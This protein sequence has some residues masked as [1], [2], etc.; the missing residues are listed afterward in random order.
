M[1]LLIVFFF[2]LSPKIPIVAA[3]KSL[4]LHNDMLVTGHMNTFI[5]THDIHS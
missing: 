5:F 1:H 4:Q 3:L 2:Q